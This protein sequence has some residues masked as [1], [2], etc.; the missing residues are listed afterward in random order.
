MP[1]PAQNACGKLGDGPWQLSNYNRASWFEDDGYSARTQWDIGRPLDSTRHLRFV[2]QLQWQEDY[3]TLE[4]SRA[5]RSTACSGT[6]VPFATPV[7]WSVT[8]P[9]TRA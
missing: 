8:A 5:H 3:D 1:A 7:S 6:A 4:F 9:P 2:S